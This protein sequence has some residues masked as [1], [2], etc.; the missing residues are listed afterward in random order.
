MASLNVSLHPA[1]LEIFNSKARFKV[2]A[3]GRRFGKSHLACWLCIIFALRSNKGDVFYVAPTFQQAK[4][5]AW[6]VFKRLIPK[7]EG[8]AEDYHENTGVIKLVNGRKIHLKGSD[9]PDTLRGVGLAFCVIDEYASM[10]PSVWEQ[11][12]RPALADHKG[13]MLAIGTPAGRNHFYDLYNY[14]SSGQDPHWEAWHF[15]SYD[16]PFLDPAE[17]DAAKASMSSFAFKQE[18]EASFE[19]AASDIFDPAW[20]KIL[21][22]EPEDGEWFVSVDLCG[23]TDVAKEQSSKNKHLDEHAIVIAKCS[24]R[25]WWI[26][27]IQH[28]RWDVRETAIRILNAARS[29]HTKT[30][31]IEKGSLKNAVSPYLAEQQIRTGYHVRLVDVTHGNQKKTE[32]IVWSLQGRM[33]KGQ[34]WF[35]RGPWN[36]VLFDQMMQFPDPKTHD[37]LVDALA[38][39]DQVVIFGPDDSRSEISDEYEVLD[40]I[41][42]Y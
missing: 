9:R 6:D 4:D 14:A 19:A 2:V 33:E 40:P 8:V 11:V 17:V 31:G 7:G 15:T 38:Y 32:R 25:G 5:V 27:D 37:D 1:Q 18:F 16:N 23:F 28:G 29:V 36:T 22:E 10:K 12:I 35:N 39:L 30:V 34:I 13:S 3:A 41:S 42:G 26:K 24:Y 20:F 21:E